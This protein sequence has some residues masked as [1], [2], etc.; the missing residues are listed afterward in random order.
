MV[1]KK[2]DKTVKKKA[3]KKEKKVAAPKKEEK[4]TKESKKPEEVPKEAVKKVEAKVEEKVQEPAEEKVEVPAP[5]PVSKILDGP[6]LRCLS[7]GKYVTSGDGSV[8]FP[9]PN[10]GESMGRCSNCRA[11]SR[12]YK[13]VCGFVGP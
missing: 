5:R 2:A 11:L 6:K 9:C 8:T 4:Q 13:C 10:C 7:C 1:K 3:E 12:M